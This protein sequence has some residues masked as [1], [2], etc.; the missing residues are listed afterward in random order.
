MGYLLPQIKRSTLV[1]FVTILILS[2]QLEFNEGTRLESFEPA[3][4]SEVLDW[5]NCGHV[6]SRVAK[7][8]CRNYFYNQRMGALSRNIRSTSGTSTIQTNDLNLELATEELK[9]IL[10]KL[11]DSMETRS[12]Q[13]LASMITSGSGGGSANVGGSSGGISS[14][15]G[16]SRGFRM[17]EY[18]GIPTWTTGLPDDS[19]AHWQPMRGKR[20]GNVALSK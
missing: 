20:V 13:D 15:G 7:Q 11:V 9:S 19:A 8:L 12:R 17:D 14:G 1:Q 6:R 10:P 2:S 16:A 3:S 5:F 18:S 4:I